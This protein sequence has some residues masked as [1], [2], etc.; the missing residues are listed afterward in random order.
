MKGSLKAVYGVAE[1]ARMAGVHRNTMTRLLRS[2]GVP[3]VGESGHKK[4]V[5]LIELKT[6][7]PGLWA[8]MVEKCRLEARVPAER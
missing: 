5:L 6:A 1:L 3:L 8:S 7:F 4:H 2:N